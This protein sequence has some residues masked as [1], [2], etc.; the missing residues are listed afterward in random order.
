[1]GE[2]CDF[3]VILPCFGSGGGQLDNTHSV[4]IKLNAILSHFELSKKNAEL[5]VT[6]DPHSL[7]N[8][9]YHLLKLAT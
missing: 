8:E 4:I 9:S 3:F 1:M 2:K 6:I 5:L 7:R